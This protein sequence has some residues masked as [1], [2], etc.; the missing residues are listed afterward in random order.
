MW[1]KKMRAGSENVHWAM[2]DVKDLSECVEW[3]LALE[4]AAGIP[5]AE[6]TPPKK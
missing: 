1:H 4:N 2:M 3:L 5:P 6:S